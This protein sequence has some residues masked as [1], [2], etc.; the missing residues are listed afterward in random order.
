MLMLLLLLLQSIAT[1]QD[2][3]EA[4]RALVARARADLQGATNDK[5][6]QRDELAAELD[7]VLSQQRVGKTSCVCS[8]LFSSVLFLCVCFFALVL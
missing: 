8:F 4:T 3:L 1:A 6:R 5:N 7:G 2:A